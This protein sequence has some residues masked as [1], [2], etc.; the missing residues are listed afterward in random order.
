MGRDIKKEGNENMKKALFTMILIL[1]MST[2][3]AHAQKHTITPTTGAQ[4]V[5]FDGVGFSNNKI[6][7]KTS[8]NGRKIRLRTPAISKNKYLKL[9][10]IS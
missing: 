10:N 9:V 1:T 7:F 5:K 4:G 8:V 3:M 2:C 6:T